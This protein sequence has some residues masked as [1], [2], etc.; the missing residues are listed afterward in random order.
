M[1]SNFQCSIG[2]DEF[3]TIIRT[4]MDGFLMF[5]IN[6]HILEV[7]DSYCHLMGYSRDELL[8]V[9][10][11]AIDAIDSD[12]DVATRLEKL[13]QAGSLRFETKHRRKDGSIVDVEVSSNYSPLHGGSVF[14]FIRDISSQ[15]QIA[16]RLKSREM[17]YR[18]LFEDASVPIWE[19]DFSKIKKYFDQLRDEGV[20]DFRDYFESHAESVIHCTELVIINDLNRASIEFFCVSSKM[21][22]HERLSEYFIDESLAVFRE[23]LIALAEG[24]TRF[25]SEIPIRMLNA[26]IKELIL[27]LSVVPG[28]EQSLSKVLVSFMD[29][30]VQKR[31]E[32]SLRESQQ[33]YRLLIETAS[34]GILVAQGEGL[35]FV[36]PVIPELTGYTSEELLSRPFLEFVH[37]DYRDLMRNNY[38]KRIKGEELGQ[39]YEIKILKK[40][41]SIR[42]VE[43]SGAKIEWEGQPATLNF[44]T[45]ITERKRAEEEKLELVQQLNQAQKLESLGVLAGGIAH[46]FNNILAVIV[47]NC[48]LAKMNPDEA[49]K[50]I[51]SIEKASER[52][53]ELCRQ[54][55]AY[56]GK[57]QF[58]SAQ[59]NMTT[60]ADEM[61][62]MLKATI[63]QNVVINSS[64]PSDI[65]TIKADASQ[66]RQIIMNLIINASEAIGEAQGQI[67]VS[68]AKKTVKARQ[69]EK[70]HLGNVIASGLYV[71]L[72]VSDTGCGMDDE[73]QR[74][75][76][77]PFY[78][79]KF[80]GRGMGMSAVLG[81]I[82]AHKG[83]LQLFSQPG[84]GTTIK[85]Y[86]PVQTGDFTGDESLQQV[87]SVQWQGSGSILLVDDEELIILTAN[88]ML[89]A[90]GFKVIEASNGK[91]ALEKYQKNA[92]D[93]TLV[94]TDIGMP[95]MNGYEL[96]RELKKLNP[97]LPIIISSGFGDEA[98]T[99]RIPREDIAGMVSKPYR[100]D[101]LRDVL[102][103]VVEGG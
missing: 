16:E 1:E 33:R 49:E 3:R 46:D 31:I 70:D 8:R 14:S 41:A 34:E 56:A 95:V 79:T 35:K 58:V 80:T 28:Y 11:L 24:N 73:T 69:K 29:I 48:F 91:D 26:D 55:L 54:M 37:P 43:I 72:E 44:V 71:C 45:D 13:L 17:H 82:T 25:E 32:E 86:L 23:E 50:N 68:L 98:V 77:E 84:R 93:I 59:V 64:L 38:V 88:A 30:S 66:L 53:A 51:T 103:G 74:R 83:A 2:L 96:F 42:W 87:A 100:F 94:V 102:K 67:L 12:K 5:D 6:G 9:H 65:P 78:T 15:K 36:N 52:A 61:V 99:S 10:I 7:N 57:A 81:I 62:K 76:F 27:R 19:E 4:S 40:D 60:L 85:V 18:T 90:L 22:L 75:I 21:E 101:Q 92:G 47:G 89:N 20:T 39:R 63:N 97:L